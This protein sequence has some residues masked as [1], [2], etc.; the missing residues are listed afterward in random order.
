MGYNKRA[1]LRE[2]N[3][4]I[5]TGAVSLGQLC[6]SGL[7]KLRVECLR[8]KRKGLY[9]IT[10]LIDRHGAAMG[11]PDLRH[12]LAADCPRQRAV[13]IYDQCGIYYPDLKTMKEQGRE[14]APNSSRKG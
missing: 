3:A 1:E 13:S 9:R 11:L 12:I 6:A 4:R 7:V 14:A 8:C 2:M 5:N 10:G